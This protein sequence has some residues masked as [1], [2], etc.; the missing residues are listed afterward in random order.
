MFN[1]FTAGDTMFTGLIVFGLP[2]L[3]ALLCVNTFGLLKK[4]ERGEDTTNHTAWEAI[5]TA[6]ISKGPG[7]TPGPL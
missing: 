1:D 5:L 3:A 7:E 6:I 2:V 4:I